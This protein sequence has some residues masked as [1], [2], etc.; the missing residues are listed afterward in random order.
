M[1]ERKMDSRPEQGVIEPSDLDILLGRNKYC[2]HHVGNRCFRT[3]IANNSGW[4][5]A[6]STKRGKMAVVA[7]L[8]NLIQRGGGRFLKEDLSSNQW[9]EVDN[10]AARGK[11]GHA[12]RDQANQQMIQNTS[13]SSRNKRDSTNDQSDSEGSMEA[14]PHAYIDEK[15]GSQHR[16]FAAPIQSRDSWRYMVLETLKEC[17]RASDASFNLQRGTQHDVDMNDGLVFAANRHDEILSEAWA[18]LRASTVTSTEEMSDIYSPSV[19]TNSFVAPN[20]SRDCLSYM[21]HET[22]KEPVNTS[23]SG[24]MKK[25]ASFNSQ[26][27]TQHDV[28]MTDRDVFVANCHD[29]IL[30]EA[31]AAQRASTVTCTEE[32]SDIYSPS[33]KMNN[34]NSHGILLKPRL[35]ATTQWSPYAHSGPKST[36][37]FRKQSLGDMPLDN[38]QATYSLE[39]GK[40]CEDVGSPLPL[41]HD[42][43]VS[44]EF[45]E[46]LGQSSLVQVENTDSGNNE[47]DNSNDSKMGYTHE[48]VSRGVVGAT[49]L[50]MPD[51]ESSTDQQL[52][53][54][55]LDLFGR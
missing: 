7:F 36:T 31:W 12:L 29:K 37:S 3:L 44:G 22:L 9:Q 33:V 34:F 53:A 24:A 23:E 52:D 39:T 46:Y 30:R 14:D 49:Q 42:S 2:F 51:I 21:V 1:M 15:Q 38:S 25:A 48:I 40:L 10:R 41:T 4:Y 27:G 28:D 18:A 55:V 45:A 43:Y 35:V 19:K 6:V 13:T 17:T 50:E 32:M 26:R 47:H 8:F 16:P 11:I 54:M 5:V 20:Q